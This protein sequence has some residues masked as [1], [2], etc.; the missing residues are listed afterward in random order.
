MFAD[1]MT[2]NVTGTD[3]P[4]MSRTGTA[5]NASTWVDTDPPT[6]VRREMS[7]RHAKVGK[8]GA[9][10]ALVQRHLFQIK[11]L[12]FNETLGKDEVMTANLTVTLPTTSAISA[13]NKLIIYEAVTQFILT[14]GNMDKFER[15][16]I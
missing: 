3:D 16:E 6:G 15:N 12:Q 13:A 4:I 9:N 8:P 10:G 1:P 7:I 5:P 11:H 14:S 2:L